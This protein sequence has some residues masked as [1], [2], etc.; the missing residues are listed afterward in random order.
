MY[1]FR[2][3]SQFIIGGIFVLIG[4]IHV[5]W[6]G[7]FDYKNFTVHHKGARSH[8]STCQYNDVQL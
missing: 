6:M 7:I 3:R 5:Y 1:I 8:L 4:L 2:V